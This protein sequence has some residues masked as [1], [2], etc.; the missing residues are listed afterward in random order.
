MRYTVTLPHEYEWHPSSWAKENCPSYLSATAHIRVGRNLPPSKVDYYFADEKD[1]A[2][3]A[4]R[5][6]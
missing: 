3:F 4:L 5:W 2:W 1:A 6:A